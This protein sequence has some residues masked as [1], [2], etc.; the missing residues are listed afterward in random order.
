MK[1]KTLPF[2]LLFITLP[3]PAGASECSP[4]YIISPSFKTCQTNT[5]INER[6]RCLFAATSFHKK[7]DRKDVGKAIFVKLGGTDKKR[8]KELL[9]C[10]RDSNGQYGYSKIKPRLALHFSLILVDA[11]SQKHAYHNVYKALDNFFGVGGKYTGA[12][13]LRDHYENLFR[14]NLGFTIG[15][16]NKSDASDMK[17]FGAGLRRFCSH[18]K[19]NGSEDI[20]PHCLSA[21]LTKEKSSISSIKE[22]KELVEQNMFILDK[23][24]KKELCKNRND[25]QTHYVDGAGK[26]KPLWISHIMM[27]GANDVVAWPMIPTKIK[28]IAGEKNAYKLHYVTPA[29]G[30]TYAEPIGRKDDGY[31]EHYNRQRVAILN[32]MKS[33]NP[34]NASDR[35]VLTPQNCHS[36]AD[37]YQMAEY[38]KIQTRHKYY[39]KNYKYM[40]NFCEILHDNM[41]LSKN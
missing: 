30:H 32:V 34:D 11:K 40:D 12:V 7:C 14:I 28:E 22:L 23:F 8:E 3:L 41:T 39:E 6:T 29:L 2:I 20:N 19:N 16:V 31:Y 9:F 24:R 35:F 13:H 17:I 37:V 18:S 15:S 26:R 5:S 10:Q 1:W 36:S 4:R 33:K 25:Q 38:N 21:A 27:F